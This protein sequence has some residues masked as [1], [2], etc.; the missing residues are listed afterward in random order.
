[1]TNSSA[2][3]F[4][5]AQRSRRENTYIQIIC[6][7]KCVY[8]VIGGVKTE[9]VMRRTKE[10]ISTYLENRKAFRGVGMASGRDVDGKRPF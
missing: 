5:N 9:G 10:N 2:A 8:A 7:V 6:D 3:L 1:M 4:E